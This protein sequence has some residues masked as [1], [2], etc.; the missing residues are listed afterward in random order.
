MRWV[1][2]L[3]RPLHR[4][5]IAMNS[6]YKI[7]NNIHPVTQVSGSNSTVYCLLRFGNKLQNFFASWSTTVT[8]SK[9]R[10]NQT[11]KKTLIIFLQLFIKCKLP[12]VVLN[13][14]LGEQHLNHFSCRRFT[15]SQRQR[16][17][18]TTAT[19]NEL[20]RYVYLIQF[21][22]TVITESPCRNPG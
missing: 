18:I 1:K 14:K 13:T 5:L 8:V 16:Y 19:V 9:R 2:P 3:T 11:A 17:E 4:Q 22:F 6:I 21:C 20:I 15:V 12:R 10:E 7:K